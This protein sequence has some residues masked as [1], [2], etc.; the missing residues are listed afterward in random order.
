MARSGHLLELYSKQQTTYFI[1]LPVMHSLF[2]WLLFRKSNNSVKKTYP[3]SWC[4][5]EIF[6]RWMFCCSFCIETPGALF[7]EVITRRSEMDMQVKMREDPLY[8]I[9]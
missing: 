2:C 8:A 9:R 4:S 7:S 1:S 3:S 6:C 5:P